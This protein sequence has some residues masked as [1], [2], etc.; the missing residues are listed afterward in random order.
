VDQLR[1]P[2]DLNGVAKGLYNLR[3]NAGDNYYTCQMVVK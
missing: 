3:I 1:E 2:I